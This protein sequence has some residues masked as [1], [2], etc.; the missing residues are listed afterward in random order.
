MQLSNLL[1]QRGDTMVEVLIAIAVISSILGSAYAITNNSV[2]T[3]QGSQ[4]RS[5]AT[6][7][8]ETQLEF[9]KSFTKTATVP[10]NNFCLYIDAASNVVTAQTISG[11]PP[12]PTNCLRDSSGNL[13]TAGDDRY[14]VAINRSINGTESLF[15]V[16][17]D[18]DASTGSRDSLSMVYKA[19]Q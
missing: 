7:V 13:S 14:K 3:N 2:R 18:W 11:T 19:Y 1:Q 10:S 17:V 9:L 15:T 16:L 4:E 8:A 5:V 6:K 12:H